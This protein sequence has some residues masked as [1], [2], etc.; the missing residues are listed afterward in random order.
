MTLRHRKY[1]QFDLVQN[2]LFLTITE[3]SEAYGT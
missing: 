1:Y 2:M 3:V